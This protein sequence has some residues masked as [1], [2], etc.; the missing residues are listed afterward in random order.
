MPVI[1][2]SRLGGMTRKKRPRWSMRNPEDC[3]KLFQSDEKV[4]ATYST[5]SHNIYNGRLNLSKDMTYKGWLNMSK[6]TI[7]KHEA[8][9]GLTN[10]EELSEK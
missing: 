1:A 10:L 6:N 5:P 8:V 4:A 9:N 7:L 3:D 2:P